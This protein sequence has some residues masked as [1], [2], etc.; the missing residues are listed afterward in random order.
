MGVG[1][2]ESGS[3][4]E[5]GAVDSR[6]VGSGLRSEA[7]TDARDAVAL[8]TDVGLNGRGPGSI[9]NGAAGEKKI[10]QQDL[11]LQSSGCVS[12]ERSIYLLRLTLLQE[13]EE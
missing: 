10:G 2:D 5:A 8:D 1:I 12:I 9:D 11:A 13:E 7:G 6:N 3:E 4:R